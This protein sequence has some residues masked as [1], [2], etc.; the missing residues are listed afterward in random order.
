[1]TINCISDFKKELNFNIIKL[2]NI[3]RKSSL[4]RELKIKIATDLSSYL[5]QKFKLNNKFQVSCKFS[6]EFLK[7]LSTKR[8]FHLRNYS[9]MIISKIQIKIFNRCTKFLDKKLNIISLHGVDTF[10]I[11]F[12]VAEI[13]E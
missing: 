9:K 4:C 10:S 13:I 2:L 6:K 8:F 7:I 5:K 1:M 11:K 12:C 3:H